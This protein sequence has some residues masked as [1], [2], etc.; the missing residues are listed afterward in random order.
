LQESVC[1]EDII[2]SMERTEAEWGVRA[3]CELTAPP[4][5]ATPHL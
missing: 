3:G 5:Q 4:L 2:L 1:S